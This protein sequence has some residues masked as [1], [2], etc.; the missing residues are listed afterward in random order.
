MW[1]R[2]FRDEREAAIDRSADR[3]AYLI[4]AYGLLLVVAW[5]GLVDGA[6]PFELLALVVLGGAVGAVYRL[7]H[8]TMTRDYATVIGLT[9]LLALLV[10]A[11]ITVASQ[12]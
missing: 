4:L 2:F 11:V 5:R 9:V 7:W 10:G 8:R 3:L 12:H 1:N 6:A